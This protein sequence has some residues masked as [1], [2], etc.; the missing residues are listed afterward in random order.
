MINARIETHTQRRS[1]RG[2]LA[3]NRCLVPASGYYEWTAEGSGKTKIPDDI[4]PSKGASVAFAGFYDT[5]TSAKGE[6]L[7]TFTIVT[8]DADEL[9]AR[10]HQRMPV[11][12][13][14]EDEQRW[15][16][17]DVTAPIQ[18]MEILA[19]SA[20][21]HLDAYPVS[22]MV[23][24]SSAEGELL[25]QRAT[26][27]SSTIAAPSPRSIATSAGHGRRPAGVS[28]HMVLL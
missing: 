1:Y 6:E 21:V 24:K 16:D 10:L 13:A 3:H 23:N 22:R 5:W 19:R 18:A 7:Q 12:L 20:G 8:R 9:M 2:L 14:Q 4:H 27:M 17:P 11:V 28:R 25:R 26:Y 15:A